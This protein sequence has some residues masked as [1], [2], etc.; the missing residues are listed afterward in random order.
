MKRTTL[1]VRYTALVGIMA[2]VIECAKLALMALP[3]IEVVSL[4]IAVFSYAFGWAGLLASLV[5]VSIEPLVWGM[6]SWF[7]S[8]L[9][10]WP[11]LSAVFF[12][13]G[14]RRVRGR[15][16]VAA[17]AVVLTLFF[18]VL[19]SLVDVGLFSGSFDRFFYRFGIYYARGVL[20]YVLHVASNAV[21]FLFVFKSLLDVTEK[22][23][24]KI[25]K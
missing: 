9:I 11:L 13:L 8:Y 16:T 1:A 24:L 14:R 12:F 5:F 19:T 6:G 4:L 10:Y 3:N 21:I 22:I 18:G 25:L 23:K 15:F 20:F 7:I 17:V 2:A